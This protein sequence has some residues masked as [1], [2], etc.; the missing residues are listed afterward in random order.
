LRGSLRLALV[1]ALQHLPA[2]QRAVL[3]LRDVLEWRAAEVAELLGTTTAAVNSALQRARAQLEALA[4]VEEELAEPVR[5]GHRAL[6]DRYVQ[7]F[8]T[9]DVSALLQLLR[10]DSVLEMPP[11]LTWLTGR[12]AIVRFLAARCLDVPGKSRVVRTGANGQLAAAMY[13]RGEDGVYHAHAVH[14]LTMTGTGIA[15]IVAFLDPSLFASFGLAP[16]SGV[17]A[18]AAALRA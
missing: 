2:K 13:M 10:E 18:E 12:E 5:P 4:P 17:A 15:R 3:I 16:T 1:A 14:L 11:Y 7:A 8:E 6:L 9:A